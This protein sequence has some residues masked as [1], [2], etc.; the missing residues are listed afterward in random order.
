MGIDAHKNIRHLGGDLDAEAREPPFEL[1][2]VFLSP[3]ASLV[4]AALIRERRGCAVLGPSCCSLARLFMATGHIEKR[5]NRRIGGLARG[6]RGTGSGRIT[7]RHGFLSLREQLL[8]ER[9][10]SRRNAARER[11]RPTEQKKTTE[12]GWQQPTTKRRASIK[13]LSPDSF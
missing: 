13:K 5:A 1:V 12:G 9:R 3:A 10:L 11:W 6:E 4:F 7:Q 8:R 2:G